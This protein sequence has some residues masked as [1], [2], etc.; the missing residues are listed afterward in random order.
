MFPR[1]MDEKDPPLE[2]TLLHELLH[3]GLDL[4][5]SYDA[6]GVTYWLEKYV[7]RKLSVEQKAILT[8]MLEDT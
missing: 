8:G 6:N 3:I 5:A 1:V 2:M 7:W 4:D